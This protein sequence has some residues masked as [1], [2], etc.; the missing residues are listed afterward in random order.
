MSRIG[1]GASHKQELDRLLRH[2]E[3]ELVSVD[4][5]LLSSYP[6]E[7]YVQRL[8][9]YER[10]EGYRFVPPD[11][12]LQCEEITARFGLRGLELYHKTLLV[13]LI[14]CYE[15]RRERY[16]IP[17]S[18]Q[19]L[20]LKEF[21]RILSTIE[22]AEGGY[23]LHG[24]DLF[25]KDLGLCRLKLVPCG[26]EVVDLWSG[27]PRSTLLRGGVSQLFRGAIFLTMHL[28]GL[29]GLLGGFKPVYESHWDRRLVRYFTARQ[30]DHCYVRIAE[31]L[32]L[33]PDVRGM[34]GSSWWFD[35]KIDFI[36]P[37]LH[38]L[39]QTPVENGAEVYRIGPDADA[40]RDAI[41]FSKKRRAVYASGEFMPCRY[42]M[43]WARADMLD[44]ASRFAAAERRRI[45]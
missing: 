38:F 42:M 6:I 32:Q 40:I 33:N 41:Q 24:N 43:V 45:E 26:S 39:R 7:S 21:Y 19:F 36:A 1:L 14:E 31:L 16:R 27:V 12:R 5:R 29:K 34:F 22:S 11:I 8:D 9:H 20:I 25:A 3:E 17:A 13:S 4:S 15:E 30:Y 18:I 28:G 10:K 2:L 44:W 23:Y 35:P 37:E